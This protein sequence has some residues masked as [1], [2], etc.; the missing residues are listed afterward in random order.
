MYVVPDNG[1]SWLRV[2]AGEQGVKESPG[3]V[4]HPRIRE[5]FVATGLHPSD[6]S[7]AWCSAF[8]NWVM[9]RDGK[10]GTGSAGARSWLTYG[11]RRPSE[12]GS[13]LVFWRGSKT[14]PFGHVGLCVGEA[15]P[16]FLVLGGNQ[17]NAVCVS[18]Y[19]KSRLLAARWPI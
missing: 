9:K 4:F 14:G 13:I 6:D 2:A 7:V 18:H 11:S 3:G 10:A 16:D 17:G 15:G 8:A 19:P 1:P 12:V 5:Y